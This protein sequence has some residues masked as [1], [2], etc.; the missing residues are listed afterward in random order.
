MFS[1]PGVIIIDGHVQGLSSTRALGEKEIPVW[2]CDTT[3]SIATY[4]RFCSGYS[5][6]PD[7]N[8]DDLVLHLI[9]L[10]K[11]Y[12]LTGWLLMPSND[13]AVR[14]ISRN[15]LELQKISQVPPK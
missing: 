6:C 5:I 11:K 14:T 13:H 4:S 7:Y 9:E 2:V 3:R 15:K 12:D 1:I 8:S 10:S